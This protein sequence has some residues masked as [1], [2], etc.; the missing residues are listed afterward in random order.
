MEIKG[1]IALMALNTSAWDLAWMM[2]HA[3]VWAL[4]FARVFGLCLTAPSL[5]IPELD[6]RFRLA[7]AAV[8]V[9]VLVPVVAPLV[10]SP[11]SGSITGGVWAGLAEVLTGAVLGWSAALIVAGARLAGELV[12]AQAGFSTATL[13]DPVSGEEITPLGRLYGLIAMVVFLALDGPMV[14]V[15]AL[16][17]SYQA[18]PMGQLLISNETAAL[19]FG[20][21]S[22]ALMLALR[23]AAPPALALTLA[24]IAIGW[25]GRAAPS[26]PFITL[27]LP[28]RAVLGIVLIF[29]SLTTLV[30]TFSTAWSTLPWGH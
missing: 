20:Q 16:V 30:A 10:V 27:A 4:V 21:V 5:A 11:A 19:A 25:L 6:W 22:G 1:P 13:F 7:L 23:A 12:A 15:Q 18:I 8:L 29:L 17:E 9:A 3:A 14:L 2:S 26:L 28:L 24:G